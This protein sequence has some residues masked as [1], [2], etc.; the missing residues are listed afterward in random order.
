M[1]DCDG[2]ATAAEHRGRQISVSAAQRAF[3]KARVK[4]CCVHAPRAREVARPGRPVILW[5][6]LWR[7]RRSCNRCRASRPADISRS[8]GHGLEACDSA[9]PSATRVRDNTAVDERV[10]PPVGAE[11]SIGDSW[12]ANRRARHS[13]L[14]VSEVRERSQ[15]ASATP[16]APGQQRS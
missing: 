6:P 11:L 3:G 16:R 5:V 7:M 12:R 10:P 13:T 2:V 9:Q 4:N 14:R 1:E 15:G 8:R